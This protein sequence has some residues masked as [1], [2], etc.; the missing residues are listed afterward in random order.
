MNITSSLMERK[1]Q[2]WLRANDDCYTL[3]DV[4]NKIYN[5]TMQSHAFGDTWVVTQ[6]HE[7]PQRK[8]VHIDLVVGNLHEFLD[9]L[10]EL[11][12]WVKSIGADLITGSGNP[13]WRHFPMP[14]WKAKGI[15]GSKDLR[16]DQR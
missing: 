16:D 12:M 15:I 6:V 9:G 8:A 10:P 14:G 1:L 4:L 2:K 5:G 13:G 7:F 11:E 3:E